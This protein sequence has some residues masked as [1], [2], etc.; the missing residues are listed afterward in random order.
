MVRVGGE[1]DVGGTLRYEI[2]RVIR[3]KIFESDPDMEAVTFMDSA[4]LARS[5]EGTRRWRPAEARWHN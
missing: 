4:G 1:M 5:W 2:D 3:G